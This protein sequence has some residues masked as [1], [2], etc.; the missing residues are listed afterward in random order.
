[1]APFPRIRFKLAASWRSRVDL[2]PFHVT[3]L[4][5]AEAMLITGLTKSKVSTR[6]SRCRLRSYKET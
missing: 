6:L 3:Q 2:V 5:Y 4:T 1:M